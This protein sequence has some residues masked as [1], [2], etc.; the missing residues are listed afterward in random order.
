MYD[1]AA[2]TKHGNIPTFQLIRLFLLAQEYA[3][4][5]GLLLGFHHALQAVVELLF[6]FT[7]KRHKQA[8][9]V[10]VLHLFFFLHLLRCYS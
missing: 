8:P 3:R 4:S 5:Q 1:V 2:F 9:V 10:N 7:E 6:E